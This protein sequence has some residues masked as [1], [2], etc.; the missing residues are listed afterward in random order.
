MTLADH[1]EPSLQA[2]ERAAQWLAHLESGDAT[3]Q[4]Q[5]SF[6]AW[7]ASD[8]THGLAI[9]RM[10]GIAAGGPERP[11]Q[12]EALGRLFRQP[13]RGRTAL[14][15]AAL[16][17]VGGGWLAS[18]SAPI[19]LYLADQRTGVGEVR[20]IP[21]SD[22]SSVVMATDSAI[23]L[24]S[25]ADRQEIRLL[26]GE[27]LVRVA[28]QH[29]APFTVTTRDGSAQ[30]MGTGFTVRQEEAGTQVTV[31]TSQVRVC[32]RSDPG[33]GCELLGPGQR[34]EMT[35]DG[36]T[37]LPDVDPGDA[38]G[39]SEGWLTVNDRPL[40]EVLGTLNRWRKQPVRF[41]RAEL[42]DLHVSGAFLLGIPTA[43]SSIWRIP[44]PSHST[45]VTPP[46]R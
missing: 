39:W 9:E 34:A 42:A 14:V 40:T 8:P 18:H 20:T 2:V 16:A 23:D 12:R 22:G 11:I 45:Y 44:N 27:L 19:E 32:S 38:A 10:S 5:I 43:L 36:V 41:D 25:R 26:R 1:R 15:M 17:L 30:A 35:R 7:R 37:R 13:K 3:E 6:E 29:H 46:D 4:D 31:I 33:G 21:L 28:H 24:S